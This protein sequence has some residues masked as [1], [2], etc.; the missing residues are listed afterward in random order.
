ML[1]RLYRVCPI[2]CIAAILASHS[3]AIAGNLNP[4]PGPVAP[5][6]KT[7]ND[8][9]PRIPIRAADLP[10]AITSPGSYYFVENIATSPTGISIQSSDVTIDLMGFSY[11]K[12]VGAATVAFSVSSPQENIT[13]KNGILRDWPVK[14]VSA[15]NASK[16]RFQDL[17]ISNTGTSATVGNSGLHVGD[18]CVISRCTVVNSTGRGFWLGQDNIVTDCL[19]I[20]NGFEGFSLFSGTVRNCIAKNNNGTGIFSF[21]STV[22]EGCSASGSTTG[23]GIRPGS[24]SVVKNCTTALNAGHGIEVNAATEVRGCSSYNNT[25]DGILAG[26]NSRIIGNNCSGNAIGINVNSRRSRIEDNSVQENDT[27]I[28]GIGIK[29]FIVKNS[30]ARNTTA[31]YNIAADNAVGQIIDVSATAGVQLTTHRAWANFIF[32]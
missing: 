1:K 9:E 15:A 2:V 29:N 6:M 11:S 10:L 4:P 24:G 23:S 12:G 19:A 13:I 20:G 7:L 17:F 32:E 16:S 27:G 3:L 28:G 5:T 8:V 30:A 31:D 21:S 22:I 25:G 26:G 18:A 14:A